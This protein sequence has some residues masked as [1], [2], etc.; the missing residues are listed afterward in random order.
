M[1]RVAVA[2]IDGLM[3]AL[4]TLVANGWTIYGVGEREALLRRRS[5]ALRLIESTATSTLRIDFGSA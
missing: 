2:P 4:R 5:D 3:P 1:L